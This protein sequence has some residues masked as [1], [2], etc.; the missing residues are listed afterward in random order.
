MFMFHIKMK[1]P[2][3]II[4]VMLCVFIGSTNVKA[5][6][7]LLT[8]GSGGTIVD[9]GTLVD[10]ATVSTVNCSS[11][12]AIQYRANSDC[13]TSQRTCCA[14]KL[15]SGWDKECTCQ[16]DGADC[17]LWQ[18]YASFDAI[19]CKCVCPEG[20]IEV[21][22]VCECDEAN[23]YEL[24][25]HKCVKRAGYQIKSGVF[26]IP[27][28]GSNYL[29]ADGGSS[30]FPAGYNPKSCRERSGSS[31]CYDD[32][33]MNTSVQEFRCTKDTGEKCSSSDYESICRSKGSGYKCIISSSG[34][35]GSATACMCEWHGNYCGEASGL[36]CTNIK[37]N[38]KGSGQYL[39]CE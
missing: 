18:I 2:I 25:N 4:T 16:K 23:G 36:S 9:G 31:E 38:A 3:I 5:Y 17:D 8:P 20:A 37:L 15:W 24:D 39:E 30:S 1:L 14:N 32:Y 28:Y 26:L 33:I 12:G 13:G 6:E 21:N 10:G 11:V 22:G 34:K 19:N 35:P 27:A 29:C 7:T